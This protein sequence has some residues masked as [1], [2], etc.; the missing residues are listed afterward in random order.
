MRLIISSATFENNYNINGGLVHFEL[1]SKVH[2]IGTAQIEIEIRASKFLSN[3]VS[4]FLVKAS[5]LQ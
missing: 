5:T 4:E 1:E 3:R 2:S